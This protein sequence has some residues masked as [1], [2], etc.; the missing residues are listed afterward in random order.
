MHQSFCRE[1]HLGLTIQMELPK[2]HLCL[3]Y[4]LWELL[5]ANMEKN[6]TVFMQDNCM[7]YKQSNANISRASDT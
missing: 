1:Q 4:T 6:V 7:F 5:V 2:L 3:S